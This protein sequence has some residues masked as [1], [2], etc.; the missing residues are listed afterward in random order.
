[1]RTGRADAV[2][3]NNSGESPASRG[4][5]RSRGRV[6]T[7]LTASLTFGAVVGL[8]VVAGF[9]A[10][11]QATPHLA[12]HEAAYR[13][14]LASAEPGSV[15]GAQGTMTYRMESTCAGWTLET[16]TRLILSYAQG[17]SVDNE[18]E[19][20][21]YEGQDG[22]DYNFFIRNKMEGR[23]VEVKEGRATVPGAAVF[24]QPEDAQAELAA[25]TLFPSAHTLAIL[26]AAEAGKKFVSRSVFD[27]TTPYGASLVTAFMGKELPAGTKGEL[28]NPLLDTPSWPMTI[29]FFPPEGEPDVDQDTPSYE[30]S[31]RY[32]DNGVAQDMVQDFG[33]FTLASKL[34]NLKA[35]PEPD[36]SK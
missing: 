18:W 3:T 24:Q 6:G 35:L 9:P 31:V 7:G 25:D 26:E 23:V 33:Y 19:Y 13:L 32:H 8:G 5:V 30:V 4:L 17:R 27:G 11:A 28:D 10:A 12:S 22:K 14:S 21:A 1:M 29:A 2:R 15:V 20:V 36:C 34:T 16:R